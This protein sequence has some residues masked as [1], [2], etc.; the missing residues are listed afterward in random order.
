M[1]NK[2]WPPLDL[3]FVY[4]TEATVAQ[5]FVEA[6]LSFP[7]KIALRGEE[8]EVRYSA[9]LHYAQALAL[10]LRQQ[11]VQPGARIGLAA[12]RSSSTVGAMLGIL[13]AGAAYVPLDG[14]GQPATLLRQQVQDSGVSLILLDTSASRSSAA[15]AWKDCPTH[16]I[17]PIDVPPTHER[18]LQISPKPVTLEA[19]PEDPVY[20]MFTSGST[21]RPKGVVVAHRGV[22]RL[23]SAQRFMRFAPDE[24]FLLHSPLGFDASILE[25]WG[26]LLHG[27]CLA[28]APARTLGVTDYQDLIV[29][30]G[31]TTLWLTAAIFH[32]IADHAPETFAPL[33]QLIVGGDVVSPHCVRKIRHALPHLTIVNGYGPTENTTFTT[34]YRV[35]AEV[36]AEV[37]LPLG[38]AIEHTTVFVL[39]EQ[40]Q[41]VAEGEAG[42]LV[43]GG[44]GVALGYV[45]EED[46]ASGRFIPD[47]F[48]HIPG[49]LLYRTGDRVRRDPSGLLHFLG[50][51]DSEVKIAGRRVDLNELESLVGGFTGV[52]ACAALVVG[53]AP[54]Q[55]ELAVAVEIAGGE[56]GSEAA[57]RR[58]LAE[59]MPSALLPA[60]FHLS[61]SLPLTR[62]GKVD[63]AAIRE[64]IR[65]LTILPFRARR[66]PAIRDTASGDGASRGS[67]IRDSAI[68]EGA[69]YT[70][71]TEQDDKLAVVLGIWST[72]L[73]NER[74]G[75]DDNFFDAGG[76]SL[77]IIRM[78]ALLNE[79][80]PAKLVLLDLFSA[81]TPR[82]IAALLAA[83]SSAKAPQPRQG[84]SYPTA[85][86]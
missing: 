78:H 22:V 68:H 19:V 4:P 67:A 62:N 60:R 82:K 73:M 48:S 39:D 71:A 64:E 38:R 7:D 8:G 5:L 77:Q 3:K 17:P 79:R 80:Y 54:D 47:P 31:V 41:P 72:L 16:L 81:T 58:Y 30:H 10:E 11:G 65:A 21:G 44:D 29:E 37:D 84:S 13:L 42:E 55:K 76:T 15:A 61:D 6:A 75:P 46:S 53:N 20:V 26:S 45:N 28:I 12:G 27:G 40:L 24:T 59:R 74:I 50:R 70:S 1:E 34:C 49:A 2:T 83:H 14:E 18:R 56:A 66:D 33:S 51:F 86:Q 23:V 9:L 43:T 63:R 52:R 36:D 32:L 57:L 69:I 25:L 85:R 35:P